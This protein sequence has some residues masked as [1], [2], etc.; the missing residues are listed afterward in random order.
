MTTT[1][2][3]LNVEK[4]K[5]GFQTR[6]KGYATDL[7]PELV[8]DLGPRP[9]EEMKSDLAALRHVYAAELAYDESNPAQE[10]VYSVTAVRGGKHVVL[11][12]DDTAE[13]VEFAVNVLEMLD[14][15]GEEDEF[16]EDDFRK[17]A[18][19]IGSAFDEASLEAMA[20][21]QSVNTL[22]PEP[23]QYDPATGFYVSDKVQNLSEEIAFAENH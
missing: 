13:G 6:K 11:R 7:T 16:D 9:I 10:I 2:A 5:Q 19:N 4:G 3:P 1:N 18:N 21:S 23:E 12:A 15:S 20:R 8:A 22:N 17:A 14:E